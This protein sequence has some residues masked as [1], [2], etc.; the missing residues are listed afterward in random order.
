M[1][2]LHLGELRKGPRTITGSQAHYLRRVLRLR[3]GNILTV[4]DGAGWVA[5][6]E[7]SALT[8]ISA[9]LTLDDPEERKRPAGLIRAEVA[10]IKGERLDW[11]IQKLTE[12]GVD[13][14]QLVATERSVTR[15]PKER[16]ASKLA[17]YREIVVAAAAQSHRPWLATILAPTAISAL[18]LGPSEAGF[19]LVPG[20]GAAKALSTGL[21]EAGTAV[22]RFAIGPEG[23]FTAEEGLV[24]KAA[25]YQP[26][27][28]GPQILRAETAALVAATLVASALSRLDPET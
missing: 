23:G 4:F 9:E 25:G 21:S 3:P 26:A 22:I 20:L 19:A 14:V 18:K 11:C 17:R 12:I 28:L 7:V 6:A 27:S 13:E 5:N 16:E 24:L 1:T 8:S 10:L 15:W 2:W